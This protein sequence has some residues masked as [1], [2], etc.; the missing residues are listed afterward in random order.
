MAE[1]HTTTAAKR[2]S[3][4]LRRATQNTAGEGMSART[5]DIDGYGAVK[6]DH[7]STQGPTD[8]CQPGTCPGMPIR[9]VPTQGRDPTTRRVEAFFTSSRGGGFAGAAA[10]PLLSSA[11]RGG[12]GVPPLHTGRSR[13]IPELICSLTAQA[14]ALRG[15]TPIRLLAPIADS[16]RL[17]RSQSVIEGVRVL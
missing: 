12:R 16:G 7:E 2:V 8:Y 17:P 14:T 4:D 15:A 11:R 1:E 13:S 6:G 9:G 5:R 3:W 10:P